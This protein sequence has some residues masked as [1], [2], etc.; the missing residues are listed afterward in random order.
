MHTIAFNAQGQLASGRDEVITYI[1]GD[2]GFERDRDGN[3]SIGPLD[4]V[5]K[6]RGERHHILI[7]WLTGR[8][9]LIQP[10]LP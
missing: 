5:N 10:E 6:S 7:N 4:I 2:V 3:I 8:A 1:E 9:R